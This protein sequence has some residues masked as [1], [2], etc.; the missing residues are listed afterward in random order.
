MRSVTDPEVFRANVKMNLGGIL[1]N[2][3]DG[4]NLE[5][6]IYNYVLKVL[7]ISKE[8]LLG[9]LESVEDQNRTYR[10]KTINR[11]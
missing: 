10:E 5:R 9:E 3:K 11:T 4:D 8:G 6:G 7:R 2:N 1:D